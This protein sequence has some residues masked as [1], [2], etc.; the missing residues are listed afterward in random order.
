MCVCV[1]VCVRVCVS[2]QLA[3]LEIHDD[4]TSVEFWISPEGR[5]DCQFPEPEDEE[6]INAKTIFRSSDDP[7]AEELVE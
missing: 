4:N 7:T 2:C 6:L 5:I 1:C 3:V